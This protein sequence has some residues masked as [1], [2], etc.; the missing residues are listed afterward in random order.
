MTNIKIKIEGLV[1]NRI[2]I[3]SGYGKFGRELER[4]LPT[5]KQGDIRLWISPPYERELPKGFN[6]IFT[7]HEL[8]TLPETKKDWVSNLNKYDLILVPTSWNRSVFYKSGVKKPIEVVPLGVD[9]SIY[10]PPGYDCFLMMTMHDNFGRDSSRENW[11]DT[12]ETYIKYF[13]GINDCNLVIKTWNYR[14]GA[15]EAA[16][17]EISKGLNIH[18]SLI[19]S[20]AIFDEKLTDSDLSNYISSYVSLFIK[21]AN[22]DGW[23]MPL[24]EAVA[25]GVDVIFSDIPGLQWAKPYGDTFKNKEEMGALMLTKYIQWKKKKLAREKYNSETMAE[26]TYKFIKKHYENA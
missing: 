15:L 12:L 25:C 14:V 5:T 2:E 23:S 6:A 8:N 10:S 3:T 11:R 17:N 20:I 18:K 19:P 9:I 21:N 13:K 1:G 22:R 7:M 26:L 24:N 4:L 16:I